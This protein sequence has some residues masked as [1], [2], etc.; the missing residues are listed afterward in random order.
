MKKIPLS[1]L[2]IVLASTFSSCYYDNFKKLNPEND[3]QSGVSDCDTINAITYTKDIKSILESK[4]TTCHNGSG[5]GDL[6]TWSASKSS[7]TGS[8]LFV[9]VSDVN[10]PNPMPQGGSKLSSCEIT[11][12]KLWVNT[13]QPE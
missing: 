4:C 8:Q 11:K 10:A 2:S 13:G 3:L 1:I 12:I 7:Y 6:T 5:A 9:A